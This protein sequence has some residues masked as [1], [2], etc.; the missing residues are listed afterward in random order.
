MGEFYEFGHGGGD[1]RAAKNIR[2][3]GGNEKCEQIT[4]EV[5]TGTER[6]SD[7]CALG[8]TE[9]P[10]KKGQTADKARVP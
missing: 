8:K 6:A 9:D 1:N 5:V 10:G 4:V 2:E 7:G 3:E